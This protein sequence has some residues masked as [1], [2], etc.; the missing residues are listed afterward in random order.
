MKDTDLKDMWNK[1]LGP[2]IAWHHIREWNLSEL[3]V[4]VNVLLNQEG[5]GKRPG[6][7]HQAALGLL[8]HPGL[9]E[10][11]SQSDIV[12]FLFL[13]LFWHKGKIISSKRHMKTG[14]Q[15]LS[16]RKWKHDSDRLWGRKGLGTV[17]CVHRQASTSDRR[18]KLGGG[19]D[20]GC[21]GK[22]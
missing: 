19:M 11:S 16:E 3:D 5:Q 10:G 9:T 22:W 14:T 2:G 21:A 18:Q 8:A 7:T 4:P 13:V 17:T 15:S 1:L 6:P 12:S 20:M